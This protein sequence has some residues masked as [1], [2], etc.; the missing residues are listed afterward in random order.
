MARGWP[1]EQIDAA[2]WAARTRLEPTGCRVW[3]GPGR[4]KHGYGRIQ[5]QGRKSPTLVHRLS[6]ELACGPIPEGMKVCHRCDT[7]GCTTPEHLF[8][9]TQGDNL[10]DMFAKGRGKPRGR[11]KGWREAQGAA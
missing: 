6:Y 7:P 11:A 4:D 9:G 10:R 3:I 2:W 8:V 1:I 5:I